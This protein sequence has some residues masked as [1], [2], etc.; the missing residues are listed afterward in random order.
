MDSPCDVSFLSGVPAQPVAPEPCGKS[1]VFV[2]CIA[3]F[4]EMSEFLYPP[5]TYL[6][7][8]EGSARTHETVPLARQT[9][10]GDV[11]QHEVRVTIVDVETAWPSL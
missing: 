4:P 7:V 8:K 5:G 11:S 2:V 6:S 3:V 1:H 10:R 9:S